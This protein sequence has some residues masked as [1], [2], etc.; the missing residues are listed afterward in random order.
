M[1]KYWMTVLLSVF[2]IGLGGGFSS[3]VFAEENL[4]GVSD[5]ADPSHSLNQAIN[6]VKDAIVLS[7][8]SSK[9]YI[10]GQ[11]GRIDP[12]QPAVTPFIKNG[13]TFIPLKFI[14]E[15]L[16]GTMSWNPKTKEISIVFNGNKVRLKLGESKLTINDRVISMSVPGQTVNG[17]VYLP[18]RNVVEDIFQKKLYYKDGIIIIKHETKTY[19]DSTLGELKRALTP[20]LVFASGTELFYIYND[21]KTENKK[22][23]FEDAF[24]PGVVLTDGNYFYF[25][26]STYNYTK[27]FYYK[28]DVQGNVVTTV[29]TNWDD[30]LFLSLALGGTQY[31]SSVKH[32][33]YKVHENNPSLYQAIGKGYMVDDST[34]IEGDT[35]WFT[36]H[37]EGDYAIYKLQD[38]KRKQ[39]SKKNSFLKHAYG[40]WIYYGY[41]ENKRWTLYRMTKDGGQKTK[42]TGNADVGESVLYNQKIYYLDNHSKVLRVMNP[43]GTNNRVICKLSELG[44]SIME[45]DRD[46]VYIVENDQSGHW[47]DA[48]QTLYRVSLSNGAKQKLVKLPLEFDDY[49]IRISDVSSLGGVVYYVINNRIYAIDGVGSKPKEIHHLFSGFYNGGVAHLKMNE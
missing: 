27:D 33:L 4:T 35:I 32:Q 14:S 34:Y 26:D 41:F 36:N 3:L 10:N 47:L 18:L 1:K 29:E 20:Y 28:V 8:D 24:Q 17:T 25:T 7:V 45:F 21:G 46:H 40:N 30:G 15:Q 9:V 19:S 37:V 31:Y 42:L 16:G 5:Q 22:I 44:I 49:W 38:G 2:I 11:Q 48:T 6:E 39:I 12:N 43:D 23:K 13:N